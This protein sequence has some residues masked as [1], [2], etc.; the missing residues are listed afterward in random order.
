VSKEARVYRVKLA[1]LVRKVKL[2]LLEA[3]D[4]KGTLVYKAQLELR[5]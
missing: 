3:R 1:I 5:G 4:Y 2:G